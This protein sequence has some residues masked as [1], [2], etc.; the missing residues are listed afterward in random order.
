M[1]PIGKIGDILVTPSGARF[2]IEAVS[3]DKSFYW[4]ISIKPQK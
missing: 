1:C 2:E 3:L 4:I